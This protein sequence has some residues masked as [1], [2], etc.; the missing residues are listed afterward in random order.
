[1]KRSLSSSHILY[2]FRSQTQFLSLYSSLGEETIN[3]YLICKL[4]SL[5]NQNTS[6]VI[7]L[8]GHIQV[9][10]KGLPSI[11]RLIQLGKLRSYEI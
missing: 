9:R 5:T 1:M 8:T 10:K 6:T 11:M 7:D 2:I 4:R 3:T